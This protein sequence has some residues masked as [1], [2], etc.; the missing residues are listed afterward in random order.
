LLE[1][2]YGGWQ[3]QQWRQTART[4]AAAAEIETV[5]LNW[6]GAVVAMVVCFGGV[7]GINSG[8]GITK[9]KERS[10]KGISIKRACESSLLLILISYRD[11][12]ITR[13]SI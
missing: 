10:P 13:I 3:H 8:W 11:L 7:G 9:S 6:G 4:E 1:G 5:G 2:L 12:S